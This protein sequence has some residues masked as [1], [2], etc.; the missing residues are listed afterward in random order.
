MKK[1]FTILLILLAALL[2]GC[3]EKVDVQRWLWS[4]EEITL[5][6]DFGYA[7]TMAST[8]NDV[9]AVSH[10]AL[11]RYEDGKITVLDTIY[12]A[13]APAM[14]YGASGFGDTL[15][16]LAG[17][18]RPQ[19]TEYGEPRENPDFS[20]KYTV[21]AYR[22]GARAETVPFQLSEHDVL[23]GLL[24]LSD[25]YMLCW[26][27]TDAWVVSLTEGGSIYPQQVSGEIVAPTTSRLG[28]WLWV[29]DHD[30][31][32]YYSLS[33]QLSALGDCAWPEEC[34]AN[35][36]ASSS[37]NNGCLL[38]TGAALSLYNTE[39]C[40]LV[41]LAE[42]REC[43]LS[44]ATI[45]NIVQVDSNTW[46][47]GSYVENKAWVVTRQAIADGQQTLQIAAA[48]GTSEL[49]ALV[50]QFNATHTNCTAVV[51][52]YPENA[53]DRLCTEIMAGDGPDVLNL[54]GLSLPLGSPYLEDLYP[55][56]DSDESLD[57]NTFIPTV[58]S[59]LEVN[60]T[61]QSVPATYAVATLTANTS[62]VG[63]RTSWTFR[64]M[65]TLL[66]QQ[67]RNTHL[68][69]E[70]WT[71]EEFL[72]WIASIS[73]GAFVDWENHTADY[74][75][76][77]FREQLRFCATLPKTFQYAEA[78]DR[79]QALAQLQVIQ[80]P[81]ALQSIC[82]QYDRPFTFIGFPCE[83][84]NGSFFECTTLHLGISS[85]SAKKDL[86]WEFVRYALLPEYQQA[87]AETGYL[88]VRNDVREAQLQGEIAEEM[89]DEPLDSALLKQYYQLTSQPLLFIG[90][91]EE[92]AQ[93]IQ[94]EG[95]SFFDGQRTV[96]EAAE[97][98]Q[99]RVTLYL[100]EIE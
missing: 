42:W 52:Y 45:T 4:S 79:W 11:G 37:D 65:Q 29:K 25:E 12:S 38:N 100:S 81:L 88:S 76:A 61:L 21:I 60:G 32:G 39:G 92:I 49:D 99:N 35:L 46:L 96:E 72:K 54:Y 1:R 86:A 30:A 82:Q 64:E 98:I 18:M 10:T 68:L 90:Y 48:F 91:N 57:R 47:C 15:Y 56:I 27:A 83:S 26:T 23:S 7:L 70:T 6:T 44:R 3:G 62:A 87:L 24:A 69:P 17:E 2:C 41:P 40:V 95:S 63:D 14:V 94:D 19:Y 28:M 93:I 85:D 53:Y 50:E 22:G 5:P 73:T 58:L 36:A 13:D 8:E 16:L 20:G 74:N 89:M 9:F 34:P 59:S 71:Q 55:Y 51:K 67:N 75:S 43:A 66:A 97:R 33:A 80:S 77:E 78:G 84:G 31:Y